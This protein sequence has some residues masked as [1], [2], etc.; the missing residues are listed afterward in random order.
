MSDCKILT[1]DGVRYVLRK[2]PKY[3]KMKDQIVVNMLRLFEVS[4]DK[5]G[6]IVN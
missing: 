1:F 2:S 4:E 5:F 3:M 6:A